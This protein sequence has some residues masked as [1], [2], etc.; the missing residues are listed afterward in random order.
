M[1]SHL[2]PPGLLPLG[3]HQF[4]YQAIIQ[5]Q[6]SSFFFS[7]REEQGTNMQDNLLKGVRTSSKKKK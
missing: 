4:N 6:F 5:F 2:F 3:D 1:Y 7:F